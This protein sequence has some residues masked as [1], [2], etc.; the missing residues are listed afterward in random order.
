VAGGFYPRAAAIRARLATLVLGLCAAAP[1]VAGQEPEAP[2]DVSDRLAPI[3]ERHGLVALSGAIVDAHGLVAVGAVGLRKRAAEAAVSSADLWHLGS[4]TKAMT[5]TL[6]ARLVELDTLRWETTPVEVFGDFEGRLADGWRRA[7]VEQLLA[8]RGGAPG[9]GE[10]QGE[11]LELM[12]SEPRPIVEQRAQ[13]AEL[14]LTAAPAHEPG[15]TFEYSN[16]GYVLVGAMLE[17]LTGSSWEEL[18]R[19]HLFE[20]LGMSSAGFGAPGRPD[21]LDQPWGHAQGLLGLRAVAP[22]PAADNPPAL[23]P[24]GTVHASL[25]DWARFVAL[26]LEGAQGRARL[27][28]SDSFARL[29]RPHGDDYALGWAVAERAWA[30]GRALTHAGSNTLWYFVVWAAP[31]R[32]FA[33]LVATNAAHEAAPAGCDAAAAALIERARELGLGGAAR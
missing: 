1:V 31:Q 11:I 14:L 8:H 7:T 6:V 26:H 19:Q 25:A 33:V 2:S 5:A 10:R 27:I 4:C 32:G 12:R 18:V 13:A 28:S 15:S 16:V 24:A 17:R 22:G 21:A 23:G 29:Q 20:P 3:R 9:H 30:G